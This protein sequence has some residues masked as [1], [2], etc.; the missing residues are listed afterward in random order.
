MGKIEK[1]PITTV[2]IADNDSGYF[3]LRLTKCFNDNTHLRR[4][5]RT[6]TAAAYNFKRVIKALLCTLQKIARNWV[7]TI[8]QK[9]FFK[10]RL[11]MLCSECIA[12]ILICVY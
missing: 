7:R 9:M 5:E 6:L 11:F 3:V 1:S 12:S 2:I 4:S 8:S 10:R